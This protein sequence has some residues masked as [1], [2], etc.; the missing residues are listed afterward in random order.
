MRQTPSHATEEK[1]Q[2]VGREELSKRVRGSEVVGAFTSAIEECWN[3]IKTVPLPVPG[4]GSRT[5]Q[6]N[7]K[8]KR[9]S[10]PCLPGATRQT[11]RSVH[12]TLSW[13][14]PEITDSASLFSR[15]LRLANHLQIL[16]RRIPV[17]S[18]TASI[19]PCGVARAAS[20]N[21]CA[22][23]AVSAP[24]SDRR[25]VSLVRNAWS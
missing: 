18:A 21:I 4:V 2:W 23:S 8:A 10:L 13:A 9:Q 1:S 6:S 24:G 14:P 11:V 19:G 17:V 15:I 3:R 22:C 5:L 25:P 20:R 12:K 7:R 16:T